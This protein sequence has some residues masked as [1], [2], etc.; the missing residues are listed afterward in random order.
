MSTAAPPSSPTP[1]A[2]RRRLLPKPPEWVGRD[3]RLVLGASFISNLGNAGASIAAVYAVIDQGGDA[4][5]VG[6]VTA[7]RVLALVVFLL[8]GGAVAD[9][10]PRQRVMVGANV[11]NAASQAAFALLVLTGSPSLWTMALLVGLGGVGQAFF[12]P[13]SE[14][15]V[16]SSVD[17]AHASRAFSAYRLSMN[18]AMIMGAAV[19]GALVAAVGPGWVL[20]VDATCFA[21][22]AAM[23][24]RLGV[25]ARESG[26]RSG[27]VL[28]DLRDGWRE[29]SSRSWLWGIVVQ[30]GVVNSVVMAVESVYGPL[31][32]REHLGGAGPWG[33]ALAAAG[34]GTV[35]GGLLMMR[36]RPR[37]MLLVGTLGVFPL[38]LP[39]VAL[40]LVVPT[41]LLSLM[42]FA[43]GTA[44]EV[45][46]VG[47]MLALHQEIPEEKLSRVS[48]YDWLGSV[49]LTPVAAALA[50]PAASAFGRTHTLW[51]AAGLVVLLTCLVLVLP[52][53]RRLERRHVPAAGGKAAVAEAEATAGA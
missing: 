24:S 45:F 6:L 49:S 20:A 41:W 21:L 37:R 26:P 53:V 52:E 19:G 22:A 14:G 42:M 27:S 40:A 34:A 10:L 31:V 15:L 36:W 29:F 16:L 11:L 35:G 23:R 32:A 18:G 33:L 50:G 8:V 46:A 38:A 13:A 12:S 17:P 28:S 44:I 39:P 51:G 25:S 43:A 4:T 3:F 2:G 1:A 47:W 7:A 30:F 9:R 48:A 5:D